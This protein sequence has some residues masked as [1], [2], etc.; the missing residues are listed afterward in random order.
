MANIRNDGQSSVSIDHAELIGGDINLNVRNLHRT[1]HLSFAR[2]SVASSHFSADLPTIPPMIEE[3][4][5]LTGLYVFPINQ[6]FTIDAKTNYLL[7]MVRPHVIMERYGLISKYFS[8]APSSGKAQ[9]AYRLQSDRFISSGNCIVRD[10]DRIVGETRLPNLAAQN[11]FDFSLGIDPDI[12]YKENV[13]LISSTTFYDENIR[14][15][16]THY[17]SSTYRNSTRDTYEIHLIIQN[18][19]SRSITVEYQQICSTFYRIIA[20]TTVLDNNLFVRD[21]STIKSTLSLNAYDIQS[22]SYTLVV[23]Q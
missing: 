6:P 10:M 11:K 23:V 18:Y 21:D 13:T 1:E 4:E 15:K 19:K 7:P 5:E 22:Y 2:A 14:A 17:E 8:F 9:R 20:L 12:V 16:H 3:G